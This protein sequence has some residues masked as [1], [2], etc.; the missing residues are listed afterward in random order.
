M[1]PIPRKL[2]DALANDPEYKTCLRKK[3]FK[4][5]ECQADPLTGKLIEWEHSLIF[6]GRQIQERFAIIPICWLVHRGGMLD[7]NKNI[8]IALNR[9][10]D[11]ELK[12]YSKAE[13][14]ILKRD[15]LNKKYGLEYRV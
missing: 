9:A 1:R 14:L 4:D 10:T 6:G 3:I 2:K 11:A 12:K 8:C 15:Y 5:H 7:K 13:D